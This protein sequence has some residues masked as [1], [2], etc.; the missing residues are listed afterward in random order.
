MIW[1]MQLAAV[2]V[3]ILLNESRIKDSGW[4]RNPMI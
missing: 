4:R 2:I 3:A 1:N